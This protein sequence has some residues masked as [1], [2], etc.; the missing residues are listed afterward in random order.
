MK[1]W[2]LLVAF[3]VTGAAAEA[4]YLLSEVSRYNHSFFDR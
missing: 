2:A 1:C 4:R 3:V